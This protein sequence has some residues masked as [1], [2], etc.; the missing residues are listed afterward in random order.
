MALGA[1]WVIRSMAICLSC[2][3]HRSPAFLVSVFWSHGL[4]RSSIGRGSGSS[5]GAQYTVA[6]CCT[7]GYGAGNAGRRREVQAGAKIVVWP[8]ANLMV[9]KEDKEAFF[10]RAR[11]F[12]RNHDIFLLI[13][14]W[15]LEPSVPHPVENKSVLLNPA[16]EMAFSYTKITAVPGFEASVNV[17]GQGPIPVAETPYGRIASPICFYLDFPQIVRQAGNSHADIMLVPASD[18]KAIRHLH[19]LMAE[20]RAVENGVV[21]FRITR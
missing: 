7:L 5:H 4:L 10:D 11:G 17:R 16:G 2:S 15:V 3:W 19:Q 18:W 6:F 8:E 1:R 13:G 9:L 21:M 14:M 12:V 20:F